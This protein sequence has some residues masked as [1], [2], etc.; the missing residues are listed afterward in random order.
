MLLGLTNLSGY[1]VNGASRH[2]YIVPLVVGDYNNVS[3]PSRDR[4][5]GT[6]VGRD[7]PLDNSTAVY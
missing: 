4:D 6:S 7:K 2:A 3:L 1:L 5:I